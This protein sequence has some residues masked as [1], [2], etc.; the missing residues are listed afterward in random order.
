MF[1]NKQK[2]CLLFVAILLAERS[3]AANSVMAESDSFNQ[4]LTP[5]PQESIHNQAADSSKKQDTGKVIN[6]A[7]GGAMTAGAAAAAAAQNYGLAGM[8]GL[9]GALS[10]SQAL[11]DG[12]ASGFNAGIAAKTAAFNNKNGNPIETQA[13]DKSLN[14]L[15]DQQKSLIT[16]LAANGFKLDPKKLTLTTPKGTVI[17][18]KDTANSQAMMAAGVPASVATTSMAKVN[19]AIKEA[20]DKMAKEGKPNGDGGLDE[21]GGAGGGGATQVVISDGGAGNAGAGGAGASKLG[22]DKPADSSV[23]GMTKDFNGEKIGVA[24][25]DIFQMMHRSYLKN[26]KAGSFY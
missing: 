17:K 18:A 10:I 9:M 26:E 1:L 20:Q 14:D 15:M 5:Q 2:I 4:T 16:K 11:N 25:D 3:M 12:G 21:G 7:V 6:M 8:L 23:A 13:T 24:G 19:Q 22:G